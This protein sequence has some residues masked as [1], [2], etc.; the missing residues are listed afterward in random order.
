MGLF[1]DSGGGGNS[2]GLFGMFNDPDKF[3]ALA[4][5]AKG[6]SPYS[7]IDPAALLKLAQAQKEHAQAKQHRQQQLEFERRRVELAE[8]EASE[9]RNEP[10]YITR[11]D[12]SVIALPKRGESEFREVAPGVRDLDVTANQKDYNLAVRQGETRPFTE[13]TR[14]MREASVPEKSYDAE[15][16]KKLSAEQIE[17]Q[18]QGFNAAPQVATLNKMEQ[19]MD[20]PGF[21]TG[22]GGAYQA[23]LQRAWAAIGGDPKA[24]ASAEAFQAL[25]NKSVVDDLGGLGTAVSN[26]DRDYISGTVANIDK[27]PEGNRQIIGIKRKLAER[28][29]EMAKVARDY[30]KEHGGRL[31]VGFYEVA[32]DYAEKNP[33]FPEGG[34]APSSRAPSGGE[35]SSMLNE[36]RTAIQRGAPREKVIERLRKMGVDPGG[37]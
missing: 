24:P 16:G 10:K 9:R 2:G 17:I 37:L 8:S 5:I 6:A 26:T 28:K 14:A 36:A 7:E 18:K 30:A 31:D 35:P 4:M 20:T 19:L 32:A 25:A 27:T 33:L 29:Q 34:T 13:W 12:G 3:A 1:G 11:P 23:G 15:M 21:R 22:T